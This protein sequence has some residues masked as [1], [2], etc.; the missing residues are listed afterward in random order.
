MMY[1][2]GGIGSSTETYGW[3][4]QTI[5]GPDYAKSSGPGVTLRMTA[6]GAAWYETAAA[7]VVFASRLREWRNATELLSDVDRAQSH[8]TYRSIVNLG[9]AAIPFILEDMRRGGC[10]WSS[11]LTQITGEDP[12][13]VDD[14]GDCGAILRHW[15]AWF[16]NQ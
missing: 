12:V 9:R 15:L 11:A 6:I 2:V 4:A 14:A 13:P 16:D 10:G 7:Q 1:A 3:R 8:S 5:S